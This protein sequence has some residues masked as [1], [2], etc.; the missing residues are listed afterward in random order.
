[1][2]N[3]KFG[4]FDASTNTSDI[5][6][7]QGTIVQ[8]PA[9]LQGQLRYNTDFNRL[10]SFDGNAWISN[11][12][13]FKRTRATE[14][15]TFVVDQT[16]DNT[17]TKLNA[18]S[19][20][21][22]NTVLAASSFEDGF[23]FSVENIGTGTWTFNPSGGE[24]INGQL[25]MDVPAGYFATFY[26]D[27]ANWFILI[28]RTKQ[29]GDSLKDLFSYGGAI[30][31]RANINQLVGSYTV[32]ITRSGAVA[33]VATAGL[34]NNP[35]LVGDTILISGA[36]QPE[37]NGSQIVTTTPT[38][39]T[40]TYNVVGTPVTPATGVITCQIFI[41][42]ASENISSVVKNGTADFTS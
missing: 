5:R 16:F 9:P 4:T 40:F 21:I 29:L 26:T 36:V 17:L 34:N 14:T 22:F 19:T 30:Q 33:T 24:T 25:T 8:R 1:M 12:S 3:K 7:A 20:T 15:L 37:Y 39:N 32:T 41:L 10:E 2:A 28:A 13:V 31:A 42:R 23:K 11:D 35:C 38:Q 18:A 27:G 6:I